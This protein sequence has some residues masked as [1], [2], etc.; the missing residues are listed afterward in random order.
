MRPLSAWPALLTLL[1][2]CGAGPSGGG[3]APGSPEAAEV[4]RLVNATRAAPTSCPTAGGGTRVFPPAPALAYDARLEAAG[5]WFAADMATQNYFPPDHVSRDGRTSPQRLRD[6]GYTPRV[7]VPYQ[8][9]ENLTAGP[10]VDTPQ[11]AVAAWLASSE[12]C[13]TLMD[14][15]LKD[16]G[17]GHAQGGPGHV[18]VLEMGAR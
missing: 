16:V 12:H 10:A 7:G 8:T 15:L 6:F 1:V 14:P 4:Q 13:P 18:W 9:G 11:K 5:R 2:A 17:L 3:D